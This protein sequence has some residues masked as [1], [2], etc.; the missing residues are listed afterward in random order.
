MNRN[1]NIENSLDKWLSGEMTREEVLAQTEMADAEDA[2]RMLKAH[3]A[4]YIGLHDAYLKNQIQMAHQ[5]FTD[6]ESAG[7]IYAINRNQWKS[8]KIFSI[9]AS[10]VLLL[11][12]FFIYNQIFVGG[13]NLYHQFYN[14]YYLI[15]ERSDNDLINDPLANHFN[16]KDYP[17]V[18]QMVAANPAAG[19]REKFIG[20]YAAFILDD[21][22][23]AQ[24]LFKEILEKNKLTDINLYND[25]AEYFL[26]LSYLKNKEY[27]KAIGLFEKIR[28]NSF[29]IYH[30]KVSRYNLIRIKILNTF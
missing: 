27:E 22:A 2:Q 19:Q 5:H 7:K 3:K 9:A 15:N 26:A 1:S 20:G 25:E 18:L 28:A 21:H 12:L 30:E 16:S 10:I 24:I 13:E 11:G 4:A 23:L 8:R 6:I 29:H 17:K 14:D